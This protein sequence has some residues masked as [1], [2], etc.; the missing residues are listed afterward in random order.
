[1]LAGSTGI[2]AGMVMMPVIIKKHRLQ[3]AAEGDALKAIVMG[4]I[5]HH[6]QAEIIKVGR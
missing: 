2:L 5:D 4:M 6:K 3:K 1:M